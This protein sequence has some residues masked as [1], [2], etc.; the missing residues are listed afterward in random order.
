MFTSAIGMF[1]AGSSLRWVRDQLCVNLAVQARADG[2]DV[3]DVMTELAERSP[4]GRGSCCSTRAWP[5]VRRLNPVRTFAARFWVWTWAIRK[6][7]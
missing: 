4:R 1:S 2:R 6:P 3:Y 7:T 5:A